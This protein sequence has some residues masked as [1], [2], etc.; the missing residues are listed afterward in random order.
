MFGILVNRYNAKGFPVKD[1]DFRHGWCGNRPKCVSVAV[2]PE[3][4]AVRNSADLTK[5]TV[6]F[7]HDEFN[8]FADAIRNGELTGYDPDHGTTEGSYGN[9]G[10][11]R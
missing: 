2:V 1:S 3:G 7:D 5:T 8:A 6:F 10:G 9:G 11:H 4:V